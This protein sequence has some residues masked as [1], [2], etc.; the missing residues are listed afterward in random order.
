MHEGFPYA[1]EINAAGYNAFVLKYRVTRGGAD[2]AEDLAA[3][4]SYIFRSAHMLGVGMANY[5]L[6]GSSAGARLAALIGSHGVHSYGGDDLP[7]P[8]AVVMAYTG[9]SDYSSQEPPTFV[10]V[11]QHDTIAPPFKMERRLTAL[12]NAGTPV[13]YHKYENLG[14]GFGAGV[15]TSAEG[16]VATAVRFWERHMTGGRP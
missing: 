2:A 13:E 3:A 4:V 16:W 15:G 9:H 8:A 11:G 12:R 6:W 5:S 1:T 7:K 14:H 10:V